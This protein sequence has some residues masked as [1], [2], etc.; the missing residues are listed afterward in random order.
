MGVYT[1]ACVSSVLHTTDFFLSI[2]IFSFMFT[3]WVASA[4]EREMC[5]F[6][7]Y[8]FTFTRDASM[9][10][11]VSL[12]FYQ[13]NQYLYFFSNFYRCNTFR[14]YFCF[15]FAVMFGFLPR[16][17]SAGCFLWM[18][19]NSSFVLKYINVYHEDACDGNLYL[20][21]F[22]WLFFLRLGYVVQLENKR[23]TWFIIGY[24]APFPLSFFPPRQ[25]RQARVEK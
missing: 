11:C 10:V 3:K 5:Y 6:L 20:V 12:Y 24:A 21:F 4:L 13:Y 18:Y 14:Y 16:D 9:F 22:L 15:Y 1:R 23:F 17:W 2:C 25:K 19:V 7:F 8:V